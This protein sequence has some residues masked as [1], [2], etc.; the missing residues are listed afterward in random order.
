MKVSLK[1]PLV[2]AAIFVVG[3][4]VLER[5]GAP[6]SMTNLVSVSVLLTL[7]FPLYFAWRISESGETHPYRSLLKSVTLF[8]VLARLMVVPAYWLAY[9]YQWPD[10]RFGDSN[11]GVVGPDVT[12]LDGYLLVPLIL[13]L[14]WVVGAVIIGGGLGSALIAVR[15]RGLKTAEN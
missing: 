6:L 7:I 12:P 13:T 4:V 15:R 3:R 11:S 2:I 5:S 10:P 9:I 1:W 8:A 14:S